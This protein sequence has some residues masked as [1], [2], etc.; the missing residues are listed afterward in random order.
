MLKWILLALVVMVILAVVGVTFWVQTEAPFRRV[1]LAE[2]PAERA[3]I[4]YH[5]SRDAHFSDDLAAALA[6]GFE[7]GG[8]SVD[9]WP[10]TKSTPPRPEGYAVVA[11]V[12][13]TFFGAPDWPTARYLERAKLT[14]LDTIAII[15]GSG[16]TDRAERL[17]RAKLEKTGAR[18]LALRPLWIKR[19]NT[20]N[21]H[22]KDNREIAMGLARA[23]A[24][25]A[26]DNAR[27][28]KPARDDPALRIME[29]SEGAAGSRVQ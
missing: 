26:A 12:S 3:L 4:L 15:A 25:K 9:R 11:V 14:D 6:Q 13:N 17:L 10:M 21:S 24:T 22:T 2:G 27:A 20:P 18:L 1:T 28:G 19:P 29:G 16:S 7:E 8:L 23:M 5:T